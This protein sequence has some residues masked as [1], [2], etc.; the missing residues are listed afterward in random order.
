MNELFAEAAIDIIN[1]LHTERIDYE[2][3]YLPLINAALALQEYESGEYEKVV[4]AHWIDNGPDIQCSACGF[5]CDDEYYLGKKVA[6]PNCGAK[7]DKEKYQ[8]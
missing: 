3:E 1:D 2:T 6:C 7:M 4:H 5:T 8:K